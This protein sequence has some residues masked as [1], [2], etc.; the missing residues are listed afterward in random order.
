MERLR[1]NGNDMEGS[2]DISWPRM[3]RDSVCNAGPPDRLPRTLRE[4]VRC[5]RR[6]RLLCPHRDRLGHVLEGHDKDVLIV[7]A[8]HSDVAQETKIGMT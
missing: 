3:L 1:K 5:T 2:H 8:V 4:A 6:V 7:P